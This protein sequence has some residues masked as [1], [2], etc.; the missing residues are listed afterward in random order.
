MLMNKPNNIDEYISIFPVEVQEMLEKC[1]HTIKNVAPEAEEVISYGMPAFKLNG[2]LVWFAAY[3]KHIGFYP[4]ASGIEAFK[5][6][7]SMY[8][9]AKG[10]VQFPL[11][12]PMPLELIAEIVRFRLAENLQK[13]KLKK[14]K[15]V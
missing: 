11:D 8:K 2:I 13:K 9:H 6:E 1:R 7:L 14:I 15:N 3:S 4:A 10:S 5:E 12:K